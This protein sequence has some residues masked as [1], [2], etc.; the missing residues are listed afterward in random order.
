V[1]AGPT[2]VEQLGL[3][4]SGLAVFEFRASKSAIGAE[5]K[6][7]AEVPG[8]MLEYPAEKVVVVK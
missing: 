8:Y 2:P 5:L 3:V 7:G 6:K 4:E 1:E